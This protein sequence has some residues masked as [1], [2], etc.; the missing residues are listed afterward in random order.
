MQ[1][2]IF[3]P[4]RQIPV[5]DACDVFVVGG[6]IAGVSAAIAA[7]RNGAKVILAEK[8]CILGGLATA[9]LVTIY[10]P[11]CDGMGRQVSFGLAEELFRLS[12]RLHTEA[13]YPT[14]WL[15]GGTLEERKKIRYE[16]QFNAQLFALELEKILLDLGVKIL[17]DTK[18]CGVDMEG[19]KIHALIVENK[20]GRSAYPAKSVVDASGDADVCLYAGAKTETHE[21]KNI[22]AAWNYFFSKGEI[23]LHMLG[24]A[25]NPNTP[26]DS[27]EYRSRTR[28]SGLDGEENSRMVQMAHRQIYSTIVQKRE[29]DETYIPVTLPTMPQLRM[30]RRLDG[31]YTLDDTEMHK[32]FA[33]S[34]G[35]ISDWRKRGPVYEIP[36]GTLYG[37]EVKNL[38]C[39]GRCISVTDAMW[40]ISRVIPPCAVTGQ[41]AGCAAAMTD[42]FASLDIRELQAALVRDGVV[43]HES[44]L[45]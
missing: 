16:V 18:I 29:T 37:S 31:M 41:A 3:E 2:M 8:Q 45:A 42:D 24:Y 7:A 15:D 27:E 34:I 44:D 28:F 21:S 26:K 10:L 39:A 40:D 32:P 33:D 25:E 36:F 13:R 5:R 43:L 30:T 14:P 9:G 19:E 20:S 22:L 4:A 6:G 23:H 1:K 12:I 35:M 38:I 17:Y 11:L